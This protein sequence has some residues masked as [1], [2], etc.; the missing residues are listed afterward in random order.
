MQFLEDENSNNLPTDDTVLSG[1]LEVIMKERKR[2][3]S[4]HVGVQSVCRLYMGARGWEEDGIFERGIEVLGGQEEGIWLEK[5]SQSFTFSILL[6]AT[7]A[8]HDRHQFGRVS[9]IITATVE[10]CQSTSGLFSFFKPTPPKQENVHMGDI[11][12]KEDFDLVIAR[13]EKVNQD[14]AIQRTNSIGSIGSPRGISPQ[15]P[16]VTLPGSP[17][18]DDSALALDGYEAASPSCGG[19]YHRRLSSDFERV[20]PMSLSGSKLADDGG[21]IHTPANVNDPKGDKA[22]WL[23]G[24]LRSVRSLLV[25]ANPSPTGGVTQ[26]DLRKEGRVDHLGPWRFTATSDVVSVHPIHLLSIL[27]L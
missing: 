18:L 7:L 2:C 8:V 4:I 24:D 26:L 16:N 17:L 9:Y 15:L 10:G 3:Q 12:T 25:H 13:S 5:G 27:F 22:S 1:T 20:R 21:S 14:L 23:K 11:H 6:P 19:L